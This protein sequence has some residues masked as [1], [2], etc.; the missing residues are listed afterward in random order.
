MAPETA[1][2]LKAN[3]NKFFQQQRSTQ[4]FQKA[5]DDCRKAAE[6]DRNSVKAFYFWGT[7][8]V[9]LGGYDEAIKLLTKANELAIGQKVSFGDEIHNQMRL[10]RREKF[11][12]KED[13]RI[14]QE[15]ELQSYLNRLIE[16][17][18]EQKLKELN[19]NSKSS[20]S[21]SEKFSSEDGP[22]TSQ[23]PG[24]GEDFESDIRKEAITQETVNYKK[25][26]NELF[27]QVDDRRR[28]RELPDYLCGKI[29]FELLRDPVITP[30]G[31]T[32]DKA[33]IKEHLQKVGH[34][35][36][37]T[38]TP[39]SEDQLI[40]NLAM[41]EVMEHFLAQNEWAEYDEL[42]DDAGR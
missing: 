37:I 5:A 23:M 21:E 39:L 11:R 28:R 30:S 14:A 40:P 26:L 10:A 9:Q 20:D 24:E 27:M 19:L 13:K 22:S 8:A 38:R 18:L 31:I 15:I 35:D 29:S 34:F 4:Q 42:L 16:A 36:P 12:Q 41:K 2:A 25:M 1:E 33:D 3:G 6:I 17:D 7:A 32:Y